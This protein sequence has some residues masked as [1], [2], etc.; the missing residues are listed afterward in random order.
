MRQFAHA[1]N[2]LALFQF[3]TGENDGALAS[4]RHA[5]ATYRRLL[6]LLPADDRTLR[7]MDDAAR[8]YRDR[9]EEKRMGDAGLKLYD[10]TN[11]FF[12]AQRAGRTGVDPAPQQ[13][14]R[15]A[16]ASFRFFTLRNK[17]TARGEGIALSGCN[18]SRVHR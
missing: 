17:V 7:K 5:L 15:S 12:E 6:A 3:D 16:A 10:E 2:R 14:N 8:K 13:C 4:C 9:L 18:R 11:A 1:W